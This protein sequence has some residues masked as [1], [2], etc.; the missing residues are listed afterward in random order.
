MVI[1]RVK[2]EARLVVLVPK[3]VLFENID[4]RTA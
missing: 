4:M 1:I 2:R 3:S